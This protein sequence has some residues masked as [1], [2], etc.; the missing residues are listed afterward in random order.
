MRKKTPSR[1]GG[2]FIDLVVA[3]LLF[4]A[5]SS[6]R[7]LSG[8]IDSKKLETLWSSMIL[9]TLHSR[10]LVCAFCYRYAD[11]LHSSA[12]LRPEQ[13]AVSDVNT[14]AFL[15]EGA[16]TIAR[17]ISRYATFE[18]IYLGYDNTATRAV[19]G[20]K[21]ALVKLYAAILIYLGKAK[22]YFEEHTPSGSGSTF[23]PLL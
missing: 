6:A 20:L 7:L 2:G 12:K 1:N 21:E 9:Y 3:R 23:S 11:W 15:V 18:H 17:N 13:L 10:G 5:T 22:K 16:E 4:F 14:F 8:L 19:K